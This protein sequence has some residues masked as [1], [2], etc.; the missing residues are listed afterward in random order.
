MRKRSV[1]FPFLGG[2]RVIKPGDARRGERKI[3]EIGY[4]F[5]DVVVYFTAFGIAQRPSARQLL[6]HPFVAECT[7]E[8][9]EPE[10]EDGNGSETARLELDEIINVVREF[11]QKLWRQQARSSVSPTIPNFH[12]VKI[13]A[14]AEQLGIGE[15]LVRLR[16]A[17][18]LRD[19]RHVAEEFWQELDKPE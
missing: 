14:L 18:L 16:F 2:T 1:R 17:H 8:E 19:L 10:V 13:R 11:Y 3:W 12:R 4:E 6:S 5:D 7:T 9:P 15:E